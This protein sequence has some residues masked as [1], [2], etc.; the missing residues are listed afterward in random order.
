VFALPGSS[1]ALCW[2]SSFPRPF[3]SHFP[4]SHANAAAVVLDE[5]D[6]GRFKGVTNH[7]QGRPAGL[8]YACFQLADGHD[9]HLSFPCEILLTP[10]E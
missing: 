8:I 10:V 3:S 9:P 5:F 7:D 4:K 6:T 2:I 1:A